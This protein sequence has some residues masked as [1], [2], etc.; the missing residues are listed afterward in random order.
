[1]KSKPLRNVVNQDDV[2][3]WIAAFARRYRERPHIEKWWNANFRKWM[4]Q[5]YPAKPCIAATELNSPWLAIMEGVINAM[6]TPAQ[7]HRTSKNFWS[8]DS[9]ARKSTHPIDT[10]TAE[11]WVVTA[12]ANRA[13]P[14]VYIELP[15]ANE[16][17]EWERADAEKPSSG[18]PWLAVSGLWP[19]GTTKTKSWSAPTTKMRKT[20]R[21]TT[22]PPIYP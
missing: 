5:A 4:M 14:L 6:F 9:I 3:A 19:P 22:E 16:E 10:S 17:A 20:R 8:V 13:V 2:T 11:E 21:S 15:T 1:M 7:L 18:K 12:L